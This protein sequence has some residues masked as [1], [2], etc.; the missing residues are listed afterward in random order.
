LLWPYIELLVKYSLGMV[1][2]VNYQAQLRTL[3]TNKFIAQATKITNLKNNYLNSFNTAPNNH[4]DFIQD[5]IL[6]INE[7]GTNENL[8]FIAQC[9][10]LYYDGYDQN[11][12][13][14]N[15]VFL[16]K[17]QEEKLGPN[18]TGRGFISDK[19]QSINKKRTNRF[20][21]II[22]SALQEKNNFIYFTATVNYVRVMYQFEVFYRALHPHLKSSFS[23]DDRIIDKYTICQTLIAQIHHAKNYFTDIGHLEN[24]LTSSAVLYELLH[25]VG[26]NQNAKYLMGEIMDLADNY[27]IL[28]FQVK[29]KIL[30]NGGT[31]HETFKLQIMDQLKAFN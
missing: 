7:N 23:A 18:F 20:E 30:K 21:S 27:N 2:E 6:I 19:Y 4:S 17:G 13:Y 12:Q 22:N 26:D 5:L 28:E 16:L 3:S 9:E 14:L 8:R 11:I 15:E 10:L 25:Y 29:L 1:E 24:Q 31:V